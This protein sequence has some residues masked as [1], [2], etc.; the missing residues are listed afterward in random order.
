MNLATVSDGTKMCCTFQ[1]EL[2]IR[3]VFVSCKPTNVSHQRCSVLQRHL[4]QGKGSFDKA[5]PSLADEI[6]QEKSL[7]TVRYRDQI[8]QDVL[9]SRDSEKEPRADRN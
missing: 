7:T 9:Q 1:N 2:Y 5:H 4:L 3:A 8:C 6:C